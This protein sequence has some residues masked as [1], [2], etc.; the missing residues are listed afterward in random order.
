MNAGMGRAPIGPDN[1]DFLAAMPA[2]V[3]EQQAMKLAGMICW[4]LRREI[5]EYAYPANL[6]GPSFIL[7]LSMTQSAVLPGC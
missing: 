6:L 1:E 7:I 4:R 5:E 2:V 3:Y